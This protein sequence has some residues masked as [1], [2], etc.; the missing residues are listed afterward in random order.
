[1]TVDFGFWLP[2]SL[3]DRVWLDVDRNGQQ[4]VNEAGVSGVTVTLYDRNGNAIATTTTDAT[5]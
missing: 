5:G 2:A 4:D 3:G 1:M